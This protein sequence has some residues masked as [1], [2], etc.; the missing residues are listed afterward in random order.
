MDTTEDNRTPEGGRA[1]DDDESHAAHARRP[2]AAVIA[3][4]PIVLVNTLAI[5]GQCQ[6]ASTHLHWGRPGQALFAGALEATALGVM[7][8]A[9]TALIEGDS[10]WRQKMFAYLIACGS[11][12]VNWQEHAAHWRPTPPAFVFA[13][14]S[15]LSPALWATY[16]RFAARAVMR[17]AGLID[18]RAAKF[19]FARWM[20]FPRR[21]FKALRYSVWHSVQSP[22]VAIAG[23]QGGTNTGSVPKLG[24]DTDTRSR[25]KTA[26]RRVKAD[27]DSDTA[28][29]SMPDTPEVPTDSD[30][31]AGPDTDRAPDTDTSEH[32]KHSDPWWAE[33]AAPLYRQ[34]MREHNGTAPKAPMLAE[35]LAKAGYDVPPSEVRRRVIRR[36]TEEHVKANP[37]PEPDRVGAA[38]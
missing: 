10:A 12:S 25:P 1:R 24:A 34:W 19:S 6:W 17:E 21:T 36:V 28:K 20:M 14:A 16:S 38:S 37:E 29:P 18:K 5:I 23:S 3:A 22:A 11:A 32:D 15:L 27:T 2:L 33:K 4:V 26:R 7:Y 8:L 31:N 9:H 30:T 13:G 35:L